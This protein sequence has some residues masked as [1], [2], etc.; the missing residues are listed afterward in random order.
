MRFPVADPL[1]YMCIPA[2][3]DNGKTSRKTKKIQ[4]LPKGKKM[5]EQEEN[6]DKLIDDSQVTRWNKGEKK[7]V[8]HC[9]MIVQT[10]LSYPN[11][12][13]FHAYS[14]YSNN[15]C[16]YQP[17]NQLTS[18][19]PLLLPIL[20]RPWSAVTPLYYHNWMVPIRCQSQQS[21]TSR[22]ILWHQLG[23][24]KFRVLRK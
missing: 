7:I 21:K 5:K 8:A 2:F 24:L 15:C 19:K 4:L 17:Y 3:T 9:I 13:K 20:N 18:L 23:R 6:K 1:A 10:L 12:T 11:I 16:L 14:Y 22:K